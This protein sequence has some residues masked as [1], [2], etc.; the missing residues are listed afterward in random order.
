[1]TPLTTPIFDFHSGHKLSFDSDYVSDS[2]SVASEN[3]PFKGSKKRDGGSNGNLN[4]ES[5]KETMLSE[6]RVSG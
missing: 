1:M 4:G 6:M 2:D 5:A 3:Q